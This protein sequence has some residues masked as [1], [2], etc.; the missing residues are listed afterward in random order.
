MLIFLIFS[1]DAPEGSGSFIISFSIV[2][3][4]FEDFIFDF[5]MFLI[6]FL[7][8]M[9]GYCKFGKFWKFGNLEFWKFGNLE[10]WKHS[11]TVGGDI[12]HHPLQ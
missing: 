8:V 3:V 12:T 1:N 6:C 4:T 7:K 5:Q 11:L 10:I 9:I 2:F